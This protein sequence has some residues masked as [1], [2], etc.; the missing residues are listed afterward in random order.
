MI[1]TKK[2]LRTTHLITLTDLIN[3]SDKIY[4]DPTL[5]DECKFKDKTMK[6]SITENLNDS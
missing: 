6:K 3:K 2:A 4:Y 1:I 5:L